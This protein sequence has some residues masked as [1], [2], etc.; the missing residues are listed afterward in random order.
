[1]SEMTDTQNS[2]NLPVIVGHLPAERL[3]EAWAA[4]AP[5]LR[6]SQVRV[7]DDESLDDIRDNIA[8]ER[9][10]LW[11]AI[12]GQDIRGAIVVTQIRKP[13]RSMLVIEHLGGRLGHTWIPEAFG[14][15]REGAIGAGLAGIEIDARPGWPRYIKRLE[16][17]ERGK[18]N[19]TAA[20]VI[21]EIS[22]RYE[23]EL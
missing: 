10:Q 9:S 2:D 13:R 3:D 12:V 5:L 16:R 22:R 8:S 23:M 18:E 6:L 20:P 11:L 14:K 7:A 21:R 1:M 19:P 15:L 4:V 17:L